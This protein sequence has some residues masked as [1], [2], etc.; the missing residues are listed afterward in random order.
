[1]DSRSRCDLCAK[2]S[3]EQST[4][5]VKGARCRSKQE[6]PDEIPALAGNAITKRIT[7]PARGKSTGRP[8][9]FRLVNI[10]DESDDA[11]RF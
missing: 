2:T 10:N 3:Q 9:R 11:I 8:V 7:G 6:Q 1:M 5:R 4:P